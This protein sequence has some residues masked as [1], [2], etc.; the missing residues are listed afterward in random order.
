MGWFDSNRG[1][2]MVCTSFSFPIFSHSVWPRGDWGDWEWG[3]WGERGEWEW[4]SW[5][6]HVSVC[7]RIY[8]NAPIV[9]QICTYC[10]LFFSSTVCLMSY[11]WQ[12][13]GSS[14]PFV[15]KCDRPF[16]YLFPRPSTKGARQCKPAHRRF[17][18]HGHEKHKNEWRARKRKRRKKRKRTRTITIYLFPYFCFLGHLRE[19]KSACWGNRRLFL[20]AEKRINSIQPYIYNSC[21]VNHPF[22]N[23]QNVSSVEITKQRNS[24]LLSFP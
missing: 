6:A 22:Q 4:Y 19:V 11:L 9:P 7:I 8:L 20:L 10:Q 13:S 3:E 18:S 1:P 17:F 23:F 2:W 12:Q 15:K 5:R 16:P 14:W 24:I 21:W